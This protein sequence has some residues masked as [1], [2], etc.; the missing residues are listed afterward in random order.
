MNALISIAP[1]HTCPNVPR[2]QAGS[3]A[4][5]YRQIHLERNP[6]SAQFIVGDNIA[7]FAV[8]VC[9]RVYSC[10]PLFLH[11]EVESRLAVNLVCR[12]P[13]LSSYLIPGTLNYS[14]SSLA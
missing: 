8:K 3:E 9:G 2:V 1:S 7:V 13:Y 12:R 4:E 6:Q 10:A 5:R 14:R 11:F